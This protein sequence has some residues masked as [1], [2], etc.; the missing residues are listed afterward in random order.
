MATI[1]IQAERIKAAT[2][3][4]EVP[5]ENGHSLVDVTDELVRAV[6]D[7]GVTEGVAIGFSADPGCALHLNEWPGDASEHVGATLDAVVPSI[8]G[9]PDG[10]PGR[11][12]AT[13]LEGVAR[14]DRMAPVIRM[15]LGGAS[16][17]VPVRA[18]EPVLGRWQRLLLY[19][20]GEPGPRRIVWQVTGV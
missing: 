12:T 7:S 20:L 2:F 14:P 1:D 18:G 5:H 8:V 17:V 11:G 9:L 4:S 3:G 13:R 16:Q 19:G 10:E 15:V 6:K